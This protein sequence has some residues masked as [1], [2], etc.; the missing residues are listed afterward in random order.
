YV[1]VRNTIEDSGI[2]MSE[3]FLK[4]LFEPFVREHSST[5]SKVIGTGL[6]M[7]IVKRLIDLMHGTVEV[8]SEVGKGTRFTV[9]VKHRLAK[10]KD[11]A[12]KADPSEALDSGLFRGKRVLLAED[13]ALNA[14]IAIAILEEAGLT[15]D[16]AED[17]VEC[18]KMLGESEAGCYAAVLM[19]VQMPNMDGYRAT[20]K[21]RKLPDPVKAAT[22][23]IAMTA[24]AFDEDRQRAFGA[25]MN[26]FI[27]K[28]I[29]PD[30]VFRQLGNALRK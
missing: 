12:P 14:E 2:G 27:A 3:E 23:I 25:G 22:P 30:E 29:K 13:N 17:G 11:L 6:G 26:A 20:Q 9:T 7:P 18:V 8:E 28:P 5:E 21:I 19:D 15:V 1:Y 24:N 4:H 16:H 10:A